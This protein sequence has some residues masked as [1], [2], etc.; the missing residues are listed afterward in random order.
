MTLGR[1]VRPQQRGLMEFDKRGR[2]LTP[3]GRACR[4]VGMSSARAG[5]PVELTFAYENPDIGSG[6]RTLGE[7]FCLSQ[8]AASRTLQRIA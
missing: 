8:S 2:Y 1:I 3:L 7:R 6:P 5:G 4:L